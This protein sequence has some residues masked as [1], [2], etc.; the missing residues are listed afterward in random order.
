MSPISAV[1]RLECIRKK[2]VESL[3]DTVLYM[4]VISRFVLV[5]FQNAN[6]FSSTKLVQGYLNF[7]VDHRDELGVT[8][9]DISS[10]FGCIE[11]IYAFNR[12]LLQQLDLADLDCVKVSSVESSG[13]GPRSGSLRARLSSRPLF[14]WIALPRPHRR[15]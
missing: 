2:N 9:D 5:L 8:L 12:K 7:L 15:S 4:H 14:W 11:R 1:R 13:G 6:Y 10:L 3:D